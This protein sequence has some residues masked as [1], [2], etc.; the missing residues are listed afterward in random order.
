MRKPFTII[1]G[2]Y[3]LAAP[4][5]A[6]AQAQNARYVYDGKI[7]QAMDGDFAPA[8]YTQ[9]NLEDGSFT[10]TRD[11][12]DAFAAPARHPHCGLRIPGAW[13]DCGI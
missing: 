12:R 1:L 13:V 9:C 3:L 2:F 11:W 10:W 6:R 5:S 4:L 7:L 8:K